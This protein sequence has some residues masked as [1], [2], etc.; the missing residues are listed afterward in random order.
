MYNAFLGSS[1]QAGDQRP[2]VAL[3]VLD[4]GGKYNGI[5]YSVCENRYPRYTYLGMYL[6]MCEYVHE[7]M[8][9]CRIPT[10]CV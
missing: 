5:A 4:I 3:R 2:M 1:L 7:Y 9:M 10:V 8:R 6:C